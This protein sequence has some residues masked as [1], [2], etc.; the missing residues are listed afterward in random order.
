LFHVAD[1]P[2]EPGRQMSVRFDLMGAGEVFIDD[3]EVYDLSFNR[4]ELVELSKHISLMDLKLQNGQLADCLSLL[5]GYWP[6]F[7]EEHVPLPVGTGAGENLADRPA[8]PRKPPPEPRQ[9]E[10]GERTSLLDRMRDL[11]PKRL[12]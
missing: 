10:S 5:E 6:R 11:V 3:V 8:Q 1:L 9:P 4:N 7:L 2:L 12:W